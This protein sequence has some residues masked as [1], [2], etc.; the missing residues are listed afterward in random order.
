MQEELPGSFIYP[1]DY[2][3]RLMP[4]PSYRKVDTHWSIL[5]R[6][7]I[8][9]LIAEKCFNGIDSERELSKL[10]SFIT[11]TKIE[12]SGDLGSKLQPEQKELADRFATSWDLKSSNN[13]LSNGNDGYF[14]VIISKSPLASGRLLIFGDSYMQQTLLMLSYFFKVIAFCRTGYFHEEIFSS[15]KPDFVVTENAERYFSDVYLDSAAPPFLLM[16]YLKGRT[17]DIIAAVAMMFSLVLKNK[18]P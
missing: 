13:K 8:A 10:K 12:I 1:V 5:G 7:A 9:V 3:R 4:E 6:A 11:Q 14:E 16:P 2:L 17:V 15:M 18:I